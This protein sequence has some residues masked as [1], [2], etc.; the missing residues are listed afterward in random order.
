MFAF[1]SLSFDFG[2]GST[3]KSHGDSLLTLNWFWPG[4]Y[5]KKAR[6]CNIRA[7]QTVRVGTGQGRVTKAPIVKNY[8]FPGCGDFARRRVGKNKSS[9]K[10]S[11]KN[12][13]TQK[14]SGV[15]PAHQKLSAKKTRWSKGEQT[16]KARLESSHPHDWCQAMLQPLGEALFP[17][18]LS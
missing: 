15:R 11:R 5:K 14:A 7:A 8:P 2:S 18:F 1:P 6:T 13:I 9:Q 17:Y 12:K 4:K 10:A 3:G 16:C